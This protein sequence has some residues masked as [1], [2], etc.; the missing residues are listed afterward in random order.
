M[1]AT[2]M[3][4]KVKRQI[5]DLSKNVDN[6]LGLTWACVKVK[7]GGLFTKFGGLFMG[8]SGEERGEEEEKLTSEEKGKKK[9]SDC[10]REEIIRHS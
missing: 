2:A 7:F 1:L 5:S 9:K 10:V 6:G 4:E 8:F 3:S